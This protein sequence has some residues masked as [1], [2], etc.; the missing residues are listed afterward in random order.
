MATVL[1]TVTAW[2][3]GNPLPSTTGQIIDQSQAD[4][5]IA[6][7]KRLAATLGYT[8]NPDGSFTD[9]TTHITILQSYVPAAPFYDIPP[10]PMCGGPPATPN[11]V[12]PDTFDAQTAKVFVWGQS[13]AANAGRGRYTAVSPKTWV[14]NNGLYYPCS[15]PII[16]AEGIDGVVDVIGNYTAFHDLLGART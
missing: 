12:T 2:V 15:D 4:Q 14:Y 8:V 3:N 7:N 6:T 11:P 13:H 1:Q 9:P 10:H 5:V 16:G